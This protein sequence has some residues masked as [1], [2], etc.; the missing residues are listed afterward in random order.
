MHE[1][2]QAIARLIVAEQAKGTPATLVAA[3]LLQV[4]VGILCKFLSTD[5][6]Q[7][8]LQRTIDGLP[9]IEPQLEQE[10]K[11]GLLN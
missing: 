4:A 11:T 5:T 7:E 10:R 9:R 1:L 6:V 8:T 3:E 2:R